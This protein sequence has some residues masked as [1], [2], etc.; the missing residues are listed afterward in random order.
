MREAGE[1]WKFCPEC[2]AR[3][4]WMTVKLV[5]PGPPGAL[6]QG[7]QPA[8]EPETHVAPAGQ[9]RTIPLYT[10]PLPVP[11]KGT[12]ARSPGVTPPAEAFP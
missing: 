12:W 3:R 4:Y 5:T 2:G 8:S 11:V 10:V 1:P 6:D 7:P 9:A